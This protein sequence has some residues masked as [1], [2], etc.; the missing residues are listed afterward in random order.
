[1]KN[2]KTS[3]GGLAAGIPV[4]IQGILTKDILKICTGIGMIIVG[5]VAK[6]HDKSGV[7]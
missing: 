2:W 3:L 4:L 6:D 1:M 7:N 5:F